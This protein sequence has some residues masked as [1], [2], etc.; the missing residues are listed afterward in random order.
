VTYAD[1][2]RNNISSAVDGDGIKVSPAEVL[3]VVGS[4][5]I[6]AVIEEK[7]P[8]VDL[9][10]VAD[11]EV[12]R[13]EVLLDLFVAEF[14]AHGREAGSDVVSVLGNSLARDENREQISTVIWSV[15]LANL[16]RVV[17]QVVLNTDIRHQTTVSAPAS[18]PIGQTWYGC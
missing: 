13:R 8:V 11:G 16:H 18:N 15:D 6:V 5:E 4:C 1:L 9:D 10:G 12:G 14:H 2:F 7:L 3:P 17:H